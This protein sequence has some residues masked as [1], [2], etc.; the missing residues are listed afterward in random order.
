M[1]LVSRDVSA[2]DGSGQVALIPEED[3][4]MWHAY[5][6][7]AEGDSLRSTTIRKVQTESATGSTSSQK[8]RTT[9]TISVEDVDFDTAA[10][11]LRV[12]GRNIQ[13]G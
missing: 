7:I 12:K 5:N 2:K 10:C 4:D 13:V 9:L 11:M 1:K 8:V 3:E 6:I